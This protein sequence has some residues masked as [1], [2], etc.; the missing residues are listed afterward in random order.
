MFLNVTFD[1]E[2][3]SVSPRQARGF[4]VWR[5]GLVIS[6]PEIDSPKLRRRFG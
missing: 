3:N 5:A 4:S 1:A 6:G 2:D